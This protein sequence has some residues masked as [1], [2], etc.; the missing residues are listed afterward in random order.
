LAKETF[1]L[2]LK[3]NI[4]GFSAGVT[5]AKG[6]LKKL[7]DAVESMSKVGP[8]SGNKLTPELKAAREQATALLKVI[9][10]IQATGKSNLSQMTPGRASSVVGKIE[11]VKQSYSNAAPSK[12][13]AAALKEQA[14]L[15]KAL[16]IAA[17]EAQQVIIQAAKEE[18]RAK[19]QVAA[20]AR[21]QIAAQKAYNN[22]L[23]TMRYAMYDISSISRSAGQE[24]TNMS[25]AL[26]GAFAAQETA[27]SSIQKTQI[28]TK[29]ST[30]NLAKLKDQLIT[31]STTIPV[32]FSDLANIGM[33]GAQLGVETKSIAAFTE[34]VAKFSA[35]TGVSV[36]E[37]SMAFGK[38]ANTLGLSSDQYQAL[39]SS[40]AGVGVRAAATE[41]E[42]MTTASQIAAVGKNAGLTASEIIGMASAMA[43]LRILP[44]ESRG[45][46]VPTF[47]AMDAAARTFS[48]GVGKGSSQLKTF[49]EISGMSQKDFVAQWSNKSGGA[50]QVW[51]NFIRGLGKTDISSALNKLSLDGVRTSKGL[52]ALGNNAE[53]V[54]KQI[55]IAGKEGMAATF[56][57]KSFGAIVE[58]L[59]SKLKMMTNSVNALMASF[60]GN[61][62]VI[63][64]LGSL[65]D[66]ITKLSLGM[67]RLMETYPVVSFMT[68]LAAVLAAVAGAVLTLGAVVTAGVAG[69]FAFRTMVSNMAKDG[70]LASG[71]LRELV[72]NLLSVN[73]AARQAAIGVGTMAAGEGVATEATI[74]LGAS[75]KGA[76]MSAGIIGIALVAIGFIADQLINVST[77]GKEAATALDVVTASAKQMTNKLSTDRQELQDYITFL[78]D[79]QGAATGF[80]NSL[81]TM[82]E[83]IKNNGKY[84]G[85]ATKAGRDNLSALNGVINA[86]ITLSD[87][88][89]Q[90]LADN[91]EAFKKY[92]A[93]SGL[94]TVGALD[95]IQTALNGLATAGFKPAGKATISFKSM[96]E[97]LTKTANGSAAPAI[98]TVTDYMNDLNTVLTSG[99]N[100]R[101][102]VETARD[103]ITSAWNDIKDSVE[104]AKQTID[105]TTTALIPLQAK[106][107]E[108]SQKL[109][110]V[111]SYGGGSG[112][113]ATDLRSQLSDLNSQIADKQKALAD[114]QKV[115]NP[116]TKGGS[117]DAIKNRAT[118]RNIITQNNAYLTSLVGS[119][120]SQKAQSEANKLSKE[121]MAQGKAMGFSKKELEGYA[122]FFKSDFSTI[123]KG[124][125][126]T[127]QLKVN[128]NPAN[129]A[130]DEFVARTNQKLAGIQPADIRVKDG[131]GDSSTSSKTKKDTSIYTGWGKN[132]L[133]TNAPLLDIGK[134]TNQD[135][136]GTGINFN[137]KK[138]GKTLI[139]Y[140]AG[141][142]LQWVNPKSIK[143]EVAASKKEGTYVAP[144][145][146]ALARFHADESAYAQEMRDYNQK[147]AFEQM[148][149]KPT[150]DSKIASL[151]NS[152]DLFLSMYGQWIGKGNNKIQTSNF[153]NGGFVSGRG[154]GTS[155]SIL[156][157]VSNGEFVM[158]AA[159]VQ[160]YGVDFMNALNQQQIPRAMPGSND[161]IGG[162]SNGSNI[163]FLSP[164]D[165]SLLEA[166]INRPVTLRTTDRVIAQS[167]NNG[168][169]E[170]ARRATN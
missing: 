65:I 41:T 144:P 55:A 78:L 10:E 136:S 49:A 21:E 46:L 67:T 142:G 88:N 43:S 29:N 6:D 135:F 118:L 40:I 9:K 147:N 87:G 133:T 69:L 125:D 13:E 100:K 163:V 158:T 101:Y 132:P 127:L 152:M 167:A 3:A 33:L 8:G 108:L 134:P 156:A 42:I 92:L 137:D 73:V 19:R 80:E 5:A 85:N 71:S 114:A 161:T 36:N 89:Q 12:L 121:F 22:S 24:L 155:D 63:S 168:N 157:R 35:I 105:D 26:I 94:A 83:A 115:V 72:R 82:G 165:R 7:S 109:A 38:L 148:F 126:S 159:S 81:Y 169:R 139:A 150:H 2:E 93:K 129:A 44:E 31:L 123:F 25:T 104:S 170:L 23:I 30:E 110:T 47:R 96:L 119:G 45:V 18:E 131:S 66:L 124:V 15:E 51:E 149:T 58:D 61:P 95:Y 102:G 11:Q 75:I 28:G 17:K 27:F 16:A 111:E 53:L 4:R 140:V 117:P 154:T 97:A 112:Q 57:D 128:S 138:G 1:E 52:T 99:F 34:T 143:A 107:A 91:L 77:A 153:A 122:K 76:M 106:Q 70:F 164:Q 14:A 59:N 141:K 56:L 145:K 98:R 32:S 74:A 113:Y 37:T 48:E 116:T 166:A 60:A 64:I 103:A 79:T 68:S 62:V 130:I 39:G 162:G 146:K 151:T 84:F 54:F 20:A 90:I 86:M 50:S 160:N 120:Q